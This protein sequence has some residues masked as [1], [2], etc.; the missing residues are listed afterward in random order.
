[1]RPLGPPSY[2]KRAKGSGAQFA[3]IPGIAEVPTVVLTQG[4]GGGKS[5][6]STK[7]QGSRRPEGIAEATGKFLYIRAYRV[8]YLCL[9]EDPRNWSSLFLSGTY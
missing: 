3:C 1:M 2:A 8:I 7:T 5:P 6:L 9:Q 4:L